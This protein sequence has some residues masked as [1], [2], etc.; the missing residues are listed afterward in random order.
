MEVSFD[1]VVSEQEMCSHTNTSYSTR[2]TVLDKLLS[3][4]Y[5]SY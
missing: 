4:C 1:D 3:L 5:S 2:Q